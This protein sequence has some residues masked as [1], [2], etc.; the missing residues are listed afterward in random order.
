MDETFFS[1]KISLFLV[2]NLKTRAILSYVLGHQLVVDHYVAE[3]YRKILNNYHVDQNP[4]IIHSDLKAEYTGPEVR[5]VFAEENIEI[6]SATGDRHQ[7][8][9]S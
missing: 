1:E 8:Q 9:V 6:S 7:N 2:I 4:L 5:K 3:L